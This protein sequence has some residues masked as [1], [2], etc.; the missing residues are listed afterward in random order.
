MVL[1]VR[2]HAEV[3]LFASGAYTA[4]FCGTQGVRL[5]LAAAAA[6]TERGPAGQLQIVVAYVQGS[7]YGTYVMPGPVPSAA[8]ESSGGRG[9]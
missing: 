8:P 2:R 9:P 5:A 1:G 4:F 3:A 6:A 7:G